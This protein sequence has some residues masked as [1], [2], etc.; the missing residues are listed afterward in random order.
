MSVKCQACS[1]WEP[2]IKKIDGPIH[3]ASVRAGRDLFDGKAFVYCPWCGTKLIEI[4][5]LS[6]TEAPTT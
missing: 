5:N 6:N 3:L 2:Q 4:G 1:D